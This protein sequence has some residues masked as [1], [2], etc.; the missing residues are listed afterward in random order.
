MGNLYN[1]LPGIHSVRKTSALLFDRI[2]P[3][4]ETTAKFI[5]VSVESVL[6]EQSL[7]R[8]ES[9]KR[10]PMKLVQIKIQK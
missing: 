5:W 10:A 3:P 9:S 4:L 6:S 8:S 2:F 7:N 1:G